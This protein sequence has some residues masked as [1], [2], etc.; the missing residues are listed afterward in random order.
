MPLI[1]ALIRDLENSFVITDHVE[2]YLLEKRLHFTLEDK[3]MQ[4]RKSPYM[5][6]F[7]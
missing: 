7:I 2:I 1:T 5:F 4:I 6:V 3:L